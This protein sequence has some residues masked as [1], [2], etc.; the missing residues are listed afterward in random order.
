M[1]KLLLSLSLFRNTI[2][3][4]ARIESVLVDSELYHTHERLVVCAELCSH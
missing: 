2:H 1:G 4:D 3:F